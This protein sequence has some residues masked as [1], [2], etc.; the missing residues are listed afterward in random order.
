MP[1]IIA[2]K[3]AALELARRGATG[4]DICRAL[5]CHPMIASDAIRRARVKSGFPTAPVV[6][7]RVERVDAAGSDARSTEV[8]S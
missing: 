8:S 1:S 4:A 6:R 2:T 5:D 3:D 7:G